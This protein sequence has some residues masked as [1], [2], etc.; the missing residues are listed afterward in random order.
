[1]K[2]LDSGLLG[3]SRPLILAVPPPVSSFIL[4]GVRVVCRRPSAEAVVLRVVLYVRIIGNKNSLLVE[5][6]HSAYST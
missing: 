6:L 3:Y 2:R 5:E 1:M 4:D